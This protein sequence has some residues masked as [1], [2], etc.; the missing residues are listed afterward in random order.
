KMKRVQSIKSEADM[1]DEEIGLLN[2][3]VSDFMP[4]YTYAPPMVLDAAGRFF[5]TP[6]VSFTARIQRIIFNLGQKNPA[7]L[8]ASVILAESIGYDPFSTPYHVIGSNYV[9]K[10][11]YFNNVF[12]D[13]L[14]LQTL[15]PTKALNLDIIR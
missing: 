14:S 13:L 12:Q 4:D 1:N 8:A 11:E 5:V 9:T 10:D 6:F 3:M 7:T 2:S 15:F